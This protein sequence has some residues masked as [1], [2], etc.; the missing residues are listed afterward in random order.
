MMR[1]T[2]VCAFLV[3]CVAFLGTIADAGTPAQAPVA[4]QPGIFKLGTSQAGE[5]DKSS[6]QHLAVHVKNAVEAQTGGAL[7][8][9]IYPGNQLGGEREVIESIRLGSVEMACLSEGAVPGFFPPIQVLSQPYFFRNEA[10]AWKVLDGPFGQYLSEAMRQKTGIRVLGFGENGMRNFTNSVRP[11]RKPEDLKGLKMRT[12]ETP[13]HME[14]M[15]ALGAGPVP[16]PAPETYT[17][18]QQKMVDG[19]ENPLTVINFFRYDEVQKYAILDGHIY[20]PHV[21]MVNDRW[22][23]GLPPAQQ[24]ILQDAVNIGKYVARGALQNLIAQAYNDLTKRG[25]QIYTPTAEEKEAFRKASQGRVREW[26]VKNV[27]QEWVDR[28]DA[29]LKEAEK[30][31]AVK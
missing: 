30:E 4:S 31:L 27:G 15:K 22:F 16:V 26:I 3:A 21:I 12:M 20:S 7:K 10:V 5:L 23:K 1:R 14:M 24:V 9:Q 25:M 6:A 19:Q 18:M 8:V 17:A 11:I 2:V 29:A 28:L 13:A